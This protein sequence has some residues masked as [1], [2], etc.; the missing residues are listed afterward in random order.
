MKWANMAKLLEKPTIEHIAHHIRDNCKKIIVLTGA[1]IS[2]SSG[3]PDFRTPGTGLYSNLEKYRLPYPEAIFDLGYFRVCC[4]RQP[5]ISFPR[6]IDVLTPTPTVSP[7]VHAGAANIC[8]M[9]SK[10][11]N[12]FLA[13]RSCN[14]HRNGPSRFTH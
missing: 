7:N 12:I 11:L 13:S 6:S 5:V 8:T 9:P 10:K 3:I 14:F 1:G 4:F 2:T